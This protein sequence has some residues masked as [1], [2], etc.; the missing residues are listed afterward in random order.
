DAALTAQQIRKL[1]S[2]QAIVTSEWASTE[3][4]IELAGAAAERVHVSQFIDRNN[5]SP[6]YLAF[7]NAYK[8][9]FGGQ[10]PGFAGMA[11]YDTALVALEALEQ[12]KPGQSLKDSIITCKTF[13]GA[14]QKIT[15]DQ[16]GD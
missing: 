4:F 9:R 5:R 10:E 12:R 2:G 1:S 3:R 6:R 7:V 8:E 14:Q 16:F 15:I 13:E 11:G